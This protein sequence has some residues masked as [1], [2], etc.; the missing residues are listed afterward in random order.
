[1]QHWRFGPAACSPLTIHHLQ[2]HK[3]SSTTHMHAPDHHTTCA[4][5]PPTPQET[6]PSKGRILVVS[7]RPAGCTLDLVQELEVRGACYALCPFQGQLLATVNSRVLL[8]RNAK[9]PGG[10][11]AA[12]GGGWDLVEAAAISVQTTSLYLATR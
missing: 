11:G 4:C 2:A 12:G 10:A 9:G 3:L 8:L 1:M 6:E 7:Y 5:H